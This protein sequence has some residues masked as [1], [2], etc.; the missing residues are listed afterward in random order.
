MGEG[1]AF[2]P[3]HISGFFEM[4]DESENPL[5]NGS[6]NCGFCI[7]AGVL[8]EVEAVESS[9][10]DLQ[11]FINGSKSSAKTSETAIREILGRSD[12]NASVEVKHSVYAPVGAGYGMSGAGALG[13]VLALS[14]ALDLGLN[15]EDVVSEAHKAEVLCKS[16]LGD[17]GPEMMGGLVIGLEP[18]APPYGRWDR[19]EVPDDLELLCGTMGSLSTSGLLTNPDFQKRIKKLGKR[20]MDELLSDK[21]LENFM[22]ISKNFALEIG[23][24]DEDFEKAVQEISSKSPYGA[25]IVL[26]G[27]AVFAPCPVS[28]I[29]N[30]KQ[31]F[32]DYFGDEDIMRTSIN[33]SGAEVLNK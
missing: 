11:I 8:T 26:L 9:T 25:S 7:D 24:F 23:V 18:G 16:G 5:K 1:K 31:T 22:K 10:T 12:K 29:D 4:F 28:K 33:F 13:A 32:L 15:R 3:G 17:V 19:I 14:Q 30:L 2:V 27:K 20:A 21:S 6:R